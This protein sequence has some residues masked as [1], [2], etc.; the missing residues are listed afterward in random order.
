[1]SEMLDSCCICK[2]CE[3]DP[4]SH[5]FKIVGTYNNITYYYTCP[6]EAT[7]Y[8]DT[9]GILNHYD[10]LLS[11]NKNNWA[12]IFNCKGFSAK[13]LLEIKVGIELAKLITNK[14]SDT[15]QQIVIINKNIYINTVVALI[16][17]FLNDSI[18]NKITVL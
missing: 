6:A 4:S 15:L 3:E 17:P 16:Y 9:E 1:M 13:H 2:I 12:W 18:Q 8:Y 14:Y 5:S 11:L 7:K 10:A